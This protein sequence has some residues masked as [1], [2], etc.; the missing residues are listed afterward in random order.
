MAFAL[1]RAGLLSTRL[2]LAAPLKVPVRFFAVPKKKTSPRRQ[3]IRRAGQ[4]AKY[5]KTEFAQYHVCA[6]CMEP[7]RQH[8]LH[9]GCKYKRK[10]PAQDF[11]CGFWLPPKKASQKAMET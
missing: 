3:R 5:A 8:T 11:N 4:R 1:T 2:P 10:R 7:Y 9:Y 6:V